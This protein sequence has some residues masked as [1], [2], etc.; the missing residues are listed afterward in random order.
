VAFV[1]SLNLHRRHLD[2]SQRAMVGARAKP[3]FEEEARARLVTSTGGSDPQPLA[4]L[5]KAAPVH[6]RDKAASLVN[7]SPRS[8][9]HAS[10]VMESGTPELIKAVDQGTV[11]VSAAAEIASLSVKEQEYVI[12]SGQR[13]VIARAREIRN[14]FVTFRDVR[15]TFGTVYNL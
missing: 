3:M 6:S 13:E 10:S 1:L 4:N 11:S 5:P 12:S 8:V 14:D 7:V 9:E 15:S 2:E